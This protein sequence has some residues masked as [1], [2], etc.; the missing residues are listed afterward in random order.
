MC[1]WNKVVAAIIFWCQNHSQ[2]RSSTRLSWFV[3]HISLSQR[4]SLGL[5]MMHQWFH[6]QSVLRCLP[7]ATT[8]SLMQIH[9]ASLLPLVRSLVAFRTVLLVHEDE[10]SSA[11]NN[12]YMLFSKDFMLNDDSQSPHIAA[13]AW[14]MVHRGIDIRHSLVV[15]MKGAF[16]FC[17]VFFV[18]YREKRRLGCLNCYVDFEGD[19]GHWSSSPSTFALWYLL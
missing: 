15:G 16:P 3:P 17:V 13:R 14:D 18:V 5:L 8:P 4:A 1:S 12:K 2:P 6:L 7:A 11:I 19:M 9:R 10:A